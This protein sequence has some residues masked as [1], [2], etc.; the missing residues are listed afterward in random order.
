[1]ADLWPGVRNGGEPG[2]AVWYEIAN[3][4]Y[5]VIFW[6][7]MDSGYAVTLPSSGPLTAARILAALSNR[8]VHVEKPG[9]CQTC[10]I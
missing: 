10:G 4:R 8:L 1:M 3:V 2:I 5:P 9:S 6:S 7:P